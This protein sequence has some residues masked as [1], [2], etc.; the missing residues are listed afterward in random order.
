MNPLNP[1]AIFLRSHPSPAIRLPLV[2]M[3]A[4]NWYAQHSGVQ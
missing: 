3:V 1:A 2:Q 4:Q